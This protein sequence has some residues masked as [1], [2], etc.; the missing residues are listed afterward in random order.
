MEGKRREETG[1][2]E[3]RRV[4]PQGSLAQ[5]ILLSSRP[6]RRPLHLVALQIRVGFVFVPC[7]KIAAN[8][9]DLLT[10]YPHP[11]HLLPLPDSALMGVLRGVF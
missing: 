6:L 11:P 3:K 9:A 2:K 7:T 4:R 10:W 5:E 8:T 1:G